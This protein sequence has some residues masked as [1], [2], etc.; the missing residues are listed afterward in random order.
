MRNN[1]P[2]GLRDTTFDGEWNDVEEVAGRWP[3][4]IKVY[5]AAHLIQDPVAPDDPIFLDFFDRGDKVLLIGA[6]KSRKSFFALQAAACLAAGRNM[7]GFTVTMPRRILF[8][9]FE[10]KA[11]HFHKRAARM[12]ARLDISP[13]D[14]GDRLQI[15][16]L[17]GCGVD[18]ASLKT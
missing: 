16:N 9:N 5:S 8:L 14:L 12:C 18:A 3:A 17:R 11:N 1:P 10:I 4:P 13:R 7:L 15:A 2:L 6:S